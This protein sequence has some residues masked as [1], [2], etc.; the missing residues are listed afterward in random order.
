MRRKVLAFVVAIGATVLVGLPASALDDNSVPLSKVPPAARKAAEKA[1]PGIKITEAFLDEEEGEKFYELDGT[2]PQGRDVEVDVT[3]QGKV[4]S[5]AVEIPI[6]DVPK[7][8]VNALH[9]KLK[10]FMITS[11]MEVKEEGKVVEY[12][13]EGKGAKGK[14]LSVSV[15]ADGSEV[16]ID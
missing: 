5:I 6:R 16:S 12:A 13:F 2:D 11:V 7:V 8:V 1:V 3:P 10:G 4:L 9:A 14:D 15:T